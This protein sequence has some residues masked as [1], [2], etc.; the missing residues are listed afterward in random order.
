[1]KNIPNDA[2]GDAIRQIIDYGV[3][4]NKP[5]DVDFFVVIPNEKRG[6]SFIEEL[7]N[8]NFTFSLEYDDEDKEWTCYCTK[9]MFLEHKDITE[10]ERYL[11]SHAKQ[12]DGYIDGF[13]TFGNIN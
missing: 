13:G 4:L 10:T 1:M 9:S 7:K 8:E 3:D 5:M 12:F 2:T 11:D 6:L